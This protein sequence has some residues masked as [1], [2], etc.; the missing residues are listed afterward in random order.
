MG[1]K[2]LSRK[3]DFSVDALNQLVNGVGDLVLSDGLTPI[4]LPPFASIS[5]TDIGE[6]LVQ[7]PGAPMEINQCRFFRVDD[8]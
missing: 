7:Q 6:V 8:Q 5:I 4:V 2:A 3:F 1:K